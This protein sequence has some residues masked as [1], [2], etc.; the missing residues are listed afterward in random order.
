[1]KLLLQYLKPYK[2]LIALALLLAAINQ[3]NLWNPG[4]DQL[5]AEGKKFN[6]RI[7]LDKKA[8]FES[9]KQQ[10]LATSVRALLEGNR[11]IK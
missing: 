2:W 9:T 8:V 5:L 1:M 6:L 10:L 11:T 4:F 3:F 7:P